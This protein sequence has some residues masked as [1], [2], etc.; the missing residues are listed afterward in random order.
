MGLGITFILDREGIPNRVKFARLGVECEL[1]G[2]C[3]DEAAG[4]GC[5]RSDR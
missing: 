3:S 4:A 1:M 5:R 2:P